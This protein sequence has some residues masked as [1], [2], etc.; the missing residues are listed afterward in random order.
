MKLPKLRLLLV[1]FFVTLPLAF[2]KTASSSE[3]VAAK[4][5]E[6]GIEKLDRGDIPGAITDYKQALKIKPDY[7]RAYYD[8][9][10]AYCL[11]GEPRA[12][13]IYFAQA[14][15]YDPTDAD[16]FA[17]RGIVRVR[18]GEIRAAMPDF[19]QALK[20]NPKHVR[21]YWGRGQALQFQGEVRSA[22]TNYNFSIQFDRKFAQVYFDRANAYVELGAS[23]P[24]DAADYKQLA[25][26]DY[27]QAIKLKPNFVDAY[28]NRGQ[29]YAILG[30]KVVAIADL[31][32]A[33][34][35]Y[36]QKKMMSAYQQQINQ[37]E[38]LKEQ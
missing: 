33:A 15:K 5:V 20:L 16:S 21:A 25:V 36:S 13:I 17:E 34:D 27:T 24:Q 6:R 35:I 2:N 28:K 23:Y 18:I 1:L 22:I 9:G 11:L 26:A 14:I 7:A 12:E 38:Q 3:T 8:L 29:T 31:Q 4:F 37:I 10:T 30:K 32:K 19:E